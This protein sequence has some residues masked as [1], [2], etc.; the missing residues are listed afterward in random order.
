MNNRSQSDILEKHLELTNRTP[1]HEQLYSSSGHY[2]M[3]C[4]NHSDS[5]GNELMSR[6]YLSKI[7]RNLPTPGNKLSNVSG[8]EVTILHAQ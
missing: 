8:T 5:I 4:Y 6:C 2:E 3:L 7:L 1:A